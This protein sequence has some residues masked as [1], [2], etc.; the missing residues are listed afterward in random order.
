MADEPFSSGFGLGFK[1]RFA[2]AE[3]A[4]EATT[5]VPQQGAVFHAPPPN[6]KAYFLF[7]GVAQG[8]KRKKL[9]GAAKLSHGYKQ[10]RAQLMDGK[11]NYDKYQVL[12]KEAAK[13]RKHGWITLN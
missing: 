7:H 4:P 8:A 10:A 11:I 12:V 1:S 9:Y 13:G 6:R 5:E 3:A 2:L